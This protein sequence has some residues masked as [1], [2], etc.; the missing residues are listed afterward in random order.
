LGGECVGHDGN[1]AEF[2]KT[3]K[4]HCKKL[5]KHLFDRVYRVSFRVRP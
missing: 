2:G 5:G 4:R 1:L 3:L